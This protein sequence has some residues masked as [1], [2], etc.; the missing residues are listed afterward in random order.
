MDY[1]LKRAVLAPSIMLE[2]SQQRYDEIKKATQILSAA[3]ALEETYDLLVGN[4]I[5]LE[6]SALSLAAKSMMQAPHHYDEMFELNAQMNRRAVNFLTTAKMFVDQLQQRIG[7]CGGDKAAAKAETSKHYDM[8]FEYR[9]MEA[10]RNHA[11]HSGSAVHSLSFGGRWGPPGKREKM[12][13]ATEV[14]TQ[15]RFLELDPSFKKAVLLECPESVDFLDAA[16]NY[17]AALSQVHQHARDQIDTQVCSARAT[18]EDVIAVYASH[19]ADTL[20]L[21]AYNCTESSAEKTAVFLDWDNVRLK[22]VARN[23]MNLTLGR[24]VVSSRPDCPV[25]DEDRPSNAQDLDNG[26]ARS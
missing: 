23:L 12:V 7:T 8:L 21:T 2:I 5:E 11:Q 10:L 15:R 17:L 14:R 24:R 13:F 20:G 4:F 16:R 22:L 6:T 3:F 9:F 1:F 26:Q 19:E 25:G 18:I